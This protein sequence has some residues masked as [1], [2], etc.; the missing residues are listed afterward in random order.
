MLLSG[1]SYVL[2]ES[3][4]RVNAYR[5]KKKTNNTRCYSKQYIS[6]TQTPLNSTPQI[7]HSR[8]PTSQGLRAAPSSLW[9]QSTAPVPDF[10]ALD[11]AQWTRQEESFQVRLDVN[12]WFMS[13]SL[14]DSGGQ[15]TCL[16]ELHK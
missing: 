16:L 11:G 7:L 2:P 10:E 14:P 12:A 6:H 1:E 3:I 4:H 9:L 13:A 15:S 8:F 5:K